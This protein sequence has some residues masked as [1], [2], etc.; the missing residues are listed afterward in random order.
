MTAETFIQAIA[1]L[2][3]TKNFSVDLDGAGEASVVRVFAGGQTTFTVTHNLNTLDAIVQVREISSG[4]E[5]TVDILNNTVNTTQAVFN[6]NTADNIYRI[7]I[8]G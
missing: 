2:N 1:N 3:L 5:V 8:I 6:G 7:T 4:E